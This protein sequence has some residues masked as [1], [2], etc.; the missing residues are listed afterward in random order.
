VR[1]ERERRYLGYILESIELIERWT[2]SGH[3]TFLTDDLVQNATLYRLETLAEATSKLSPVLRERH[4]HIGWRDI[5]DFRNRVSH[6]YIDLDLDR[7]WRVIEIELPTLKRS[8]EQ[9]FGR[10]G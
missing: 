6:G 2:A 10:P 1:E 9:E 4:P 7:V 3:D 5:T 8:I